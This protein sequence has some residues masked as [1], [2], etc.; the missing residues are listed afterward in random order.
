MLSSL[1]M[2]ASSGMSS[3]CSAVSGSC[4]VGADGDVAAATT[5]TS[6]SP[7]SAEAVCPYAVA[8]A[9]A[10]RR[11]GA[12]RALLSKPS[13][14]PKACPRNT[15]TRIAR[16]STR[17]S[18]LPPEKACA[19]GGG[20]GGGGKEGRAGRALLHQGR[21]EARGA[22][23][24]GLLPEVRGG[25]GGHPRPRQEDAAPPRH[26]VRHH[27][28]PGGGSAQR[29]GR[30]DNGRDPH[31]QRPGAGDPG[32]AAEARQGRAGRGRRQ[33]CCRHGSTGWP[34]GRGDAPRRGSG[35]RAGGG[36]GGPSGAGQ[37]PG[38]V[39]D[40]LPGDGDQ[41]LGARDQVHHRR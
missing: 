2:I 32:G 26:G 4:V 29:A 15:P 31:R 41:H 18:E 38:P 36:R 7:P 5:W 39:G 23:P 35:G 13:T 16:R 17:V 30:Q 34:G 9:A 3:F 24:A 28:G 12:A 19:G 6:I 11:P 27:R 20:A 8:G 14:L 33:A 1:T 40:A 22:P 10:L 25:A 37:R 21:R